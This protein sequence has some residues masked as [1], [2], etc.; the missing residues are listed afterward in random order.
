MPRPNKIAK[1]C[2][3]AQLEK[4]SKSHKPLTPINTNSTIIDNPISEGLIPQL[5]SKVEKNKKKI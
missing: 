4:L 2:R 5:N 3:N 1:T